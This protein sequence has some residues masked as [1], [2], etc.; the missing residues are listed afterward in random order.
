MYSHF[1]T[2]HACDRRTDRLTEG[3]AVA[4]VG[5]LYALRSILPRVKQE[6]ERELE[7]QNAEEI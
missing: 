3:I 5:L 1:D 4:Y 7:K 2:K 6:R